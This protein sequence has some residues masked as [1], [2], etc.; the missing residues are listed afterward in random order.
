L[1]RHAIDLG[2]FC[3][4]VAAIVV[5]PVVHDPEK[6]DCRPVMKGGEPT[7][8]GTRKEVDRIGLEHDGGPQRTTASVT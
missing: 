3:A 5:P 1:C 6:R 8:I 2:G 7:V 4:L